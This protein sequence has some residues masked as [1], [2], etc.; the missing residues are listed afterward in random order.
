M[1]ALTCVW[2]RPVAWAHEHAEELTKTDAVKDDA[3]MAEQVAKDALN[4]RTKVLRQ[5][6]TRPHLMTKLVSW[7]MSNT[8]AKKTT[9]SPGGKLASRRPK[10]ASTEWLELW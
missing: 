3:A 6:V 9:T 1:R 8:L 10:V 7:L 5:F 4:T 2:Y